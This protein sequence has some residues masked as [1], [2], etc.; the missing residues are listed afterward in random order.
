MKEMASMADMSVI[1]FKTLFND[2]YKESPYHHILGKKLIM[3]RELLQSGNYSASQ[4][5]YK[6]GFIH[7]SGFARLFKHKFKCTSIELILNN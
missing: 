3:A 7:P 2:E 6:V 4:V 5:S 1:K